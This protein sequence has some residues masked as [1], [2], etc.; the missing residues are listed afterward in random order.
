MKSDSVG[1]VL[2]GNWASTSETTTNNPTTLISH[3]TGKIL[4]DSKFDAILADYLIGAVDGFSPYYQDL[5][6]P[7]LKTHLKPGGK[8]YVG[9]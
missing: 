3:N 8:I 2:I 6:L 5:I 4:P 1:Q 7:R 9:A